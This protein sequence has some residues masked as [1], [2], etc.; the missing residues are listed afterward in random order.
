MQDTVWVT[1][2]PEEMEN[3]TLHVRVVYVPAAQN[4]QWMYIKSLMQL[5]MWQLQSCI[6]AGFWF[7]RVCDEN[8]VSVNAE[9]YSNKTVQ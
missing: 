1:I 9:N 6:P 3:T 7:I 8:I 2:P 4:A 5:N